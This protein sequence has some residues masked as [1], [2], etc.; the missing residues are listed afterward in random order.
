M[1]LVTGAAPTSAGLY[2]SAS[3]ALKVPAVANAIQLISEAVATLDPFVKRLEDGT[4]VDD[5]G[6]SLL[7]LLRDHVNGWTSSFEFFRQIVVDA[8]ASDAGGMAFV[9][10]ALDGRPLEFI[11]YLPGLL[12]FDVDQTTGER[13]YK[14]SGVLQAAR[15]RK[16]KMATS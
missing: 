8:L 5:E 7:P 16:L 15:F 14:I 3:D 2:V 10:R 11:R 6:H 9:V 4:E 1:E 13:R 12:T